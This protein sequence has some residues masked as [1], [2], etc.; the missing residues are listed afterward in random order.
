M[1]VA[2]KELQPCVKDLIN[3]KYDFE[4]YNHEEY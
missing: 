2:C 4:I 1:V 3:V